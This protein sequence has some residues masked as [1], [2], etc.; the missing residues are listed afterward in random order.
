MFYLLM[1]A[2]TYIAI[3]P[4]YGLFVWGGLRFEG[5][6]NI[7]K[8]GGV[9]I[10]PNHICYLDPPTVRALYRIERTLVEHGRTR[11]SA[12]VRRAI[13]QT[14]AALDEAGK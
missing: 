6:E 10:A 2:F 4:I 11:R 3:R 1:R 8:K 5:R 7:P 13:L 9:L 14:A 12:A